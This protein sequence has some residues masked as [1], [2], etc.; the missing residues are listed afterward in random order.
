[1]A[2][3]LSALERRCQTCEL[4]KEG[5]PLAVP[6]LSQMF[7]ISPMTVRRD[8]MQLEKEGRLRRTRGGAEPTRTEEYEPVF[9][10][11]Q[12]E[13]ER[14]KKA[15][16]LTAAD[17]IKDD[18]VVIIDIGTTLLALIR[19]LRRD[20]RLTVLTN[21]LP[22]ALELAKYPNIR[23]VLLGGI[24]RADELSLIGGLTI[25]TLAGFNADKAFLGVGG[26]SLEK[27]LTDY[28]MDE[29]EIKRMMIKTA[30]EVVLLADHIKFERVAPV[31]V[32]PLSMINTV[33]TDDGM[34]DRQAEI[35]RNSGINLITAPVQ[36]PA[37]T[38]MSERV[39][40]ASI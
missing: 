2:V 14:E 6:I 22:N 27:G 36:G 7:G 9:H 20:I 5:K 29:V 28:N 24:L 11:R 10:I 25:E 16:G 34:A 19:A 23:T 8:L 3:S 1:M 39:R 17:L 21:W 37:G 32:A 33:V 18:E 30:R 38:I 12:R 13:N 31:R 15:I 4:L 26:V 40:R 35:L